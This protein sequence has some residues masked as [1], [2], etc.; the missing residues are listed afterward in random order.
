[1]P[2][3]VGS[4]GD[5]VK[6]VQEMLVQL[7]YTLTD[8]SDSANKGIDGVFGS[9]T[10]KAVCDFQNKNNLKIDGIVGKL[11]WTALEKATNKNIVQITASIL[12]VRSGPGINNKIVGKLQKGT[13]CNILEINN[14]WGRIAPT[15]WIS[16]EYTTTLA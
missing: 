12:N 3:D 15:G 7:G 9:L 14:G 6:K 1:L 4:T 10:K 2:V 8:K 5:T 13:L 11:T 16:L